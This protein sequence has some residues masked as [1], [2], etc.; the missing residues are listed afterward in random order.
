LFGRSAAALKRNS[1]EQMKAKH[2]EGRRKTLQVQRFTAGVGALKLAIGRCLYHGVPG[3][4]RRNT[5]A[6]RLKARRMVFGLKHLLHFLFV[7]QHFLGVYLRIRQWNKSTQLSREKAW[8]QVIGAFQVRA[9]FA[10]A[11]ADDSWSRY[12]CCRARLEAM[13]EHEL[14]AKVD[15]FRQRCQKKAVQ[16]LRWI[17]GTWFR[18]SM[19]GGLDAMRSNFAEHRMPVMSPGRTIT[20]AEYRQKIEF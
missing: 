16:S 4:M 2:L 19:R 11:R 18:H 15:H 5:W 9:V 1:L 14:L 6:A 10:E 13:Q 7:R 8:T 20:F 12:Y 17:L 3:I